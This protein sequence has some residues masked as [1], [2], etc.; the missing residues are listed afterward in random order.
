MERSKNA[1]KIF[2]K[3]SEISFSKMSEG[4][5]QLEE[6]G[7]ERNVIRESDICADNNRT[8]PTLLTSQMI[9]G[10]IQLC[11]ACE[12][13]LKLLD[14]QASGSSIN[15]H[16]LK[17]LFERLTAQSQN[18][19]RNRVV[20]EMNNSTA[21]FN[22]LLDENSLGFINWRYFYENQDR[23]NASLQFLKEFLKSLKQSIV[24]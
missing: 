1:I 10:I 18:D 23:R 17:N 14:Y 7:Y 6:L 13:S 16:H 20:T 2:E 5:N 12:I 21:D 24:W 22:A 3:A 4:M 9:P 15:S 19:I 11:L 8:E